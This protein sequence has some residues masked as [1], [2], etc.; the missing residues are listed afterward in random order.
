MWDTL[1]PKTN[2]KAFRPLNAIKNYYGAQ[3]NTIYLIF[4][5]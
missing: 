1:T 3:V 4:I 5:F 2:R